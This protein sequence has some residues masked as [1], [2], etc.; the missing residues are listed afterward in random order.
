MDRER[1]FDIAA[2]IC[3]IAFFF[4]FYGLLFDVIDSVGVETYVDYG[5]EV[6]VYRGSGRSSYEDCSD[7]HV[8]DVGWSFGILTLV[9]SIGLY[10]MIRYREFPPFKTRLESQLTFHVWLICSLLASMTSFFVM[11]IVGDEY[12]GWVNLVVTGSIVYYGYK[13][14]HDA[15]DKLYDRDE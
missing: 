12:G 13:F 7:G 15:R 3:S 8:T 4:F 10:H 14:Y 11:I 6:C 5:E 1:A 2:W 9:L